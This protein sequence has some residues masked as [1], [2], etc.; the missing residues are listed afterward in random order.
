MRRYSSRLILIFGF[1]FMILII[2]A[3]TAIWAINVNENIKN[4]QGIFGEQKQTRLVVQMLDAARQRAIILHRMALMTD[5]FDVDEEYMKFK[6]MAGRFIKA[7]DELLSMQKEAQVEIAIWKQAVPKINLGGEMQQKTLQLILDGHIQEANKLLLEKVIPIQ[8]AVSDTLSKMFTYQKQAAKNEFHTAFIRNAQIFMFVLVFGATAVLL[9]IMTAVVVIRRATRIE[10]ALDGARVTAQ[11][12]TELKSQ[13][14][15]NMSHEIRTPLTAVLGFAETML[16]ENQNVRERTFGVNSILRNG[17]HLLQV[18]NDILDI[19][20]IE[21]KQLAMEKIEVSPVRILQ[22]VDS[23]MGVRVRDKG[24]QLK[25]Q[26]D[27]PLPKTIHTDPTRL[28]QVLLNLCSNAAKFTDLGDIEIRVTYNQERDEMCFS[29]RDSGIGMDE[30]EVRCLFQPFRQADEST[31][32]KYGGTGLGLYISRQLSQMMGGDLGCDS[33]KGKGSVFTMTIKGNVTAGTEFINSLKADGLHE[34]SSDAVEIP[35]LRGEILLAEDSPD[36]Q[37]LITM[38]VKKTGVQVTV[39]S[40]GRQAIERTLAHRYDLILMDM[41]MPVIDGLESVRLIRQAGNITPIAMLTANAMKTERDKCL[42]LGAN[43]FLTKPID[44]V[45][46]YKVLSQYLQPAEALPSTPVEGV[47]DEEFDQEFADL[48][49][50]FLAELPARVNKLNIMLTQVDWLAVK[51]EIHRLKGVGGG[52]GFPTITSLSKHIE[53]QLRESNED[54][55]MKLLTEL[56]RYCEQITH[57]E[58]KNRKVG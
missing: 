21:A 42:S 1:S 34:G 16:D 44:K 56:F 26:Y 17:K 54:A 4:I 45:Q 37:I 15:A 40:D 36:N 11:T 20:K 43:D 32:R 30:D 3:L 24:L 38:Y 58:T 5:P 55:A 8:N 18:I 39:V 35:Q 27:F 2:V 23:L 12:A 41:Q 6:E 31:T 49:D 7:R 13:F 28:K 52:L 53:V 48:R 10:A 25:I 19:S 51:A 46:F 9:T 33:V 29:V 50:K 22:E 57:D 47:A 14:L